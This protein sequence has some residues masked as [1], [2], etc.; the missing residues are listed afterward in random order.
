MMTD[1]LLLLLAAAGG[2]LLG[3]FYFG[4]LRWTLRR[5]LASQASALWFAGSFLLRTGICLGGFYWIGASDPVRILVCL[6]GFIVA[7][8][9]VTKLIGDP[10]YPRDPEPNE[11]RHAP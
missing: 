5:G 9:I 1:I 11:A 8:V 10:A 3:V 4:G 7:R 2:G 6:G